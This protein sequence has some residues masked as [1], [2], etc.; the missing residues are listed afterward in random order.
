MNKTNL[1]KNNKIKRKNNNIAKKIR[2]I[3]GKTNQNQH[4]K[5]IKRNQYNLTDYI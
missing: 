1:K 3:L 2:N 4:K 5:I